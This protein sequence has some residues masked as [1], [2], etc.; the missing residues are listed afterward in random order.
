MEDLLLLAQATRI[1]PDNPEDIRYRFGRK[2][3]WPYFIKL[4]QVCGIS[5]LLYRQIKF[6][7]WDSVVPESVM[8]HLKEEYIQVHGINMAYYHEL[9]GIISDFREEGIQAVALKGAACARYLYEDI[10]LRSFGDV[11]IL[12]SEDE[13][14]RANRLLQ[15]RLRLEKSIPP[16]GLSRRCSFHYLY[17]SRKAPGLQFELH[18]KIFPDD[19]NI[20]YPQKNFLTETASLKVDGVV[21]PIPSA[22][23]LF[24]HLCIHFTGHSFSSLRDLWDLAWMI[25][26]EKVPWN[27]LEQLSSGSIRNRIYYSLFL[28][29]SVFGLDLTQPLASFRPPS[30]IRRFFPKS[31]THHSLVLRIA[32]QQKD[33]RAYIA[34]LMLPDWMARFKF[35]FNLMVPGICWLTI[36]PDNENP[37]P[38]WHRC[39][40]FLR[41]LRLIGYLIVKM[42]V[43][44]P[45]RNKLHHE[46]RP[47]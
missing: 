46:I 36:Y 8:T 35:F 10:G 44:F 23:H 38:F 13:F 15:K 1:H 31:I 33:L 45:G 17:T 3:N 24:I 5:S 29:Q 32:D 26:K 22:L 7:G 2:T 39:I 25:E 20:D 47:E 27:R 6:H 41:G 19:A 4:A 16:D 37:S 11:D 42:V 43:N 30:V 14:I 40:V 34:F 28:V 9:T 18:W 12:V 21:L